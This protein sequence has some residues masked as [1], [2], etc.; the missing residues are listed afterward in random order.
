M[1]LGWSKVFLPKP[2]DEKEVEKI[3]ALIAKTRNWLIRLT[4]LAL[5]TVAHKSYF[6]QLLRI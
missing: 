2:I 5:T 3:K 6:K 4:D 1:L